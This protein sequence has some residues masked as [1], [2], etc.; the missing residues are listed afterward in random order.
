MFD[1]NVT[2]V[3]NVLTTPEWRRTRESNQLVANFRIASTAR[4]YDRE[5]RCWVDG[6]TLRIRVSAWRKLAE[7]VASSLHVGDPV[8][9]YGRVYTRDWEDE[10]GNRRVSYEMEAHSVGHDLSRGRARFWRMRSAATSTVEDAEDEAMV[11]GEQSDEVA[12]APIEFGEGLPEPLTEPD[13]LEV[14]AGLTAVPDTPAE[15]A[16]EE[17][18][19]GQTRR[20]RRARREPVAA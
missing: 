4:R 8:I 20:S 10:E 13:F 9:A 17:P 6:N 16:T 5:N 3:G 7:G 11:G 2:V 18:E 1:T 15:E 14:V 19:T 12:E